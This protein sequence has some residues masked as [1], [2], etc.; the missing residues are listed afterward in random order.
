M[1]MEP[2]CHLVQQQL[3]DAAD[4]RSSA[5][6]A[7]TVAAPAPAPVADADAEAE[8]RLA[9]DAH[10]AGCADCA[11]FAARLHRLDEQLTAMFVPPQLSPAFRPALRA[12]LRRERT[13]VWMDALP[14]LVHFGGCG[15]VTLLF[16]VLAPAS[17]P[18]ILGAGTTI[19]LLTYVPLL[20]IGNSFED[21]DQAG[22]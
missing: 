9:L 3:L 6:S 2:A 20:A 5:V 18:L 14:E 17:A 7:A 10:L 21:V 4:E 16:A 8:A 12:S 15:V 11:A 13:R 19:A 22:R 1:A